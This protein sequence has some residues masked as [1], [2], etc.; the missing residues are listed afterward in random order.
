M[1]FSKNISGMDFVELQGD[2][3]QIYDWSIANLMHVSYFI[4]HED[5][6]QAVHPCKRCAKCT[7]YPASITCL[8]AIR[9]YYDVKY[10][11]VLERRIMK[12]L[13]PFSHSN[14]YSGKNQF[15]EDYALLQATPNSLKP[16][17]IG[18]S[19]MAGRTW[20]NL[21]ELIK[22]HKFLFYYTVPPCLFLFSP[23]VECLSYRKKFHG[24]KKIPWW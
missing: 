2:I 23:L 24:K 10:S 6:L 11:F 12:S 18:P 20:L 22:F 17:L 3:D 1:L 4:F 16:P 5:K 15:Q 21:L 13:N 9:R 7:S 14:F 8:W 19:V